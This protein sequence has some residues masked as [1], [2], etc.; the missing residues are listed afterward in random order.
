VPVIPQHI[1]DAAEK[2]QCSL[3]LG[4]GA[5]QQAGAPSA[6]ELSARVSDRL[7]SA[8][9]RDLDLGTAA[10][11]AA[12]Q[13]GQLVRL[14]DLVVDTLSPIDPSRAHKMLPWFRWGTIVTTNYDR[15]IEKAYEQEPGAVQR[16]VPII[17]ERDLARLGGAGPET[18]AL[19]KPHGS[20]SDRRSI[21]ISR[22]D[23][24]EARQNRRLL[25]THI[26]LVHLVGPVIY[27][28]YSLHDV[29]ILD[30]IYDLTIR[31]GAYRKPIL[32]VAFQKDRTV[33]AQEKW[34]FERSLQGEYLAVGFDAFMEELSE[35]V[36]P[37]IGP[38]GVVRQLAPC[39]AFAI[40]ANAE[41][42]YELIR[43]TLHNRGEWECWL[44]YKIM[45]EEGFAGVA[46]EVLREAVDVSR[47]DVVKFELHVSAGPRKVDRLEA[48]K[49]ESHLRLHPKLLDISDAKGRGWRECSVP[50]DEYDGVD[51]SRLLRV[52]LADNGHRA[53]LNRE[54]KV[55]LR[56]VSFV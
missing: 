2:G 6:D 22:E 9:G 36:T 26:E 32:F 38:S 1:I 8:P 39:R 35:R 40:G 27:V 53:E 48:V 13:P 34:W 3:F 47:H 25:F 20:V 12:V 5:S 56:R 14:Q 52:V 11:L 18:L 41:I 43:P 49:L 16:V 33:A 31:L 10:S 19:L 28:G 37:V 42:S 29:H 21:S 51:I 7:L 17:D 50:L 30:M 23:V 45:D 4:A 24:Y 46:F 55:G 44:T 15:L 54:Y